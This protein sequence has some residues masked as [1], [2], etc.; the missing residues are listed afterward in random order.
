M[1]LKKRP[2]GHFFGELNS[3]NAFLKQQLTNKKNLKLLA[4]FLLQP[5]LFFYAGA[6]ELFHDHPFFLG[7]DFVEADPD[8]P[9]ERRQ[10]SLK[11]KGPPVQSLD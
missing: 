11:M 5:D 2:N 6:L 4:V 1:G 9:L 3:R 10:A 8:V 7:A